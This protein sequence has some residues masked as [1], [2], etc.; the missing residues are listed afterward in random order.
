MKINS[1]ARHESQKNYI[2]YSANLTIFGIE[3]S[4]MLKSILLIGSGGFIGS[5]ARYFISRLNLSTSFFS[6]PVGT[7][8]VNVLGSLLI[9]LLMGLAERTTILTNEARLF[10]MVGLCGGFTTFSSFTMENLSLLH[11]G[12]LLQILI[13][14]TL[15]VILGF[16]AV[17]IGYALTNLL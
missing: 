3:N 12:Q 4:Y 14:T 16:F 1:V 8:L 13:Y 5:V 17:W 6:I 10:L 2:V 9:G 15:S 11:N 7:L